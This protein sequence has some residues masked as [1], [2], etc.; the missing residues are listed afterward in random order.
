MKQFEAVIQTLER[1]GGRATLAE[2]YIETM[3]ITDCAWETKTPFASIRR[4]VQTRPEI[5][6][7]RPGLWA[8]QSYKNQLGLL[9]DKGKFGNETEQSHSF[10][11]GML[12]VIGNLRGLTTFV[13][14]QDKNKSFVKE[15]L[16]ELRTL[17]ELPRFSHDFIVKESSTIDVIWFNNRQ[18]P[19]SFFEVEFSTDMKSSLLKFYD[20]Q[21]FNARM[22]IVSHESRKKEFKSKL[23]Y[24]ALRNLKYRVN[25]LEYNMLVKQYEYEVIKAT[26]TFAA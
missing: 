5:F 10:Y 11:Q 3:K 13:P 7:V 19:D 25:F 20:L 2:L 4:I 17:Q 9:E 16:G 22:V 12:V 21:D 8:L 23:E 26:H 1:L 14:N 15:H 6:K 24:S 18:M